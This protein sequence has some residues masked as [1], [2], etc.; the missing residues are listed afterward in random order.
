MNMSYSGFVLFLCLFLL[1]LVKWSFEKDFSKLRSLQDG[2]LLN[3]CLNNIIDF[4]FH[5]NSNFEQ[6]FL[7]NK[8][9]NTIKLS[10]ATIAWNHT[11]FFPLC[12]SS[13]VF[14]QALALFQ[15]K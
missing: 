11:I 13:L 8:N 7:F 12:S 10:C 5:K 6:I 4:F 14:N 2:K 1:F 9:L 3:Q 15:V